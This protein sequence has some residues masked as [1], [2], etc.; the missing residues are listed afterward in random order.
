MPFVNKKSMK[1]AIFPLFVLILISVQVFSQESYPYRKFFNQAYDQYPQVPRGILEAVAWT[2][3]HIRHI[4]PADEAPSCTGM[5]SFY[6]VMGLVY[7]GKGFFRENLKKVSLLSGFPV[8]DIMDKPDINILAYASAWNSIKTTIREWHS[9]EKETGTIL[10]ALSEL[11][12]EVHPGAGDYTMNLFIYGVFCFLND[13]MNQIKYG[14]PRYHLDPGLLFGETNL[15]I[16]RSK[17]IKISAEGIENDLGESYQT[18]LLSG[19][20]PDYNQPNCTWI[21]S[22]NHY[23]GWNGHTISAIAIHTVQGSYTS[24]INWF[25]NP[26]A[27]AS[28]HYV[29]ASNSAY[30]GQVTQMV[31][32]QNA[33]W[34]VTSENWYAIGYEHEGYVNDPSWY[35]PVM[36]QTSADL[37]RDVCTSQNINPLR[38]FYRETLDD[39]TV[40]D[41]GLHSLGAEGSCVKIKGHQHFPGQ[42]H[43]DP[44]PNWDWDYYFKLVNSSTPV[45][46]YTA[47]NGNF[48]DSGGSAGFY[49][50]DERKFWLI[51]PPNA[52]NITLTFTRFSLED[53]YDFL[54][55]YDGSNEFA[56]LLGRFNTQSPATVTSSG[57][58]MFIEFRSDCATTDSGWIAAWTT[59]AADITDPSCQVSLPSAWANNDFQ[60][61]F[62]D[63][64]NVGGTGVDKRFYQVLEYCGGEWRANAQNGFFNDNFAMAMHSDWTVNAGGGSWQTASGSLYQSDSTSGNTNIYTP[65]SQNNSSEYLYQWSALM[66]GNTSNRRCGL[67]FFVT[68]P[69]L[70]NRGTSYLVWFRADDDKVQIYRISGDTLYMKVDQPLSISTGVWY[71]FKTAFNPVSG[72]IK[73]YMN[74]APVASWTDPSPISY[75]GYISLRSGNCKVRYDDLKV[76]RSR[77]ANVRVIAGINSNEDARC[78][79]PVPGQ[80]ACRIN[81]VVTDAAQNWSTPATGNIRLDFTRPTTTIVTPGFWKSAD[82]AATFTDSDLLSG[83]EKSFYQVLDFDGTKWGANTSRGFFGDNFDAPDT[84]CWKTPP[85]QG[86]WNWTGGTVTQTDEGVNNSNL[87]SFLNQNY[88]GSVLYHFTAM[89]DGSGTNRR[90]GFHYMCDSAS[91]SNRGNSYFVWFRLEGQTLEF[92]K[93]VNNN[94]GVAQKVCNN[95]VT[96][97]GQWYDFKVLFNKLNGTTAVF[98]NDTL[99]GTWTDPVPLTGGKYI[100]FRSG[101]SRLSV[102][103]LK[104]YR[105]RLG[106]EIVSTGPSADIRYCNPSPSV[107]GAKI[108][109]I[110]CDSAG[111]LSTVAYHDLSVDFTEP[112]AVLVSDGLYTDQDTT[113]SSSSLSANWTSSADPNSGI[114]RYLYS[115]GTVP[116][117]TDIA[118]W[119]D[120]GTSLQVTRNGLSL[121]PGQVYYFNVKSE[122][123]AGL[124]S[125]PAS[126]DGQ[127]YLPAT[128]TEELSGNKIFVM[129]NPVYDKARIGILLSIPGELR[130]EIYD[131][132]GQ[133]AAVLFE[134]RADAGFHHLEFDNNYLRLGSGVYYLRIM[135]ESLQGVHKIII[136]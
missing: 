71:D 36:Y 120:A 58:S 67:H 68:N 17:R 34:H 129:P 123:G 57:G 49:T 81:T 44:G 84:L 3:T 127:I 91:M 93:V 31:N 108:K 35:T 136:L 22:P 94:F 8:Q 47:S 62:S 72:M 125:L 59:T 66:D 117:N 41:N 90:F 28:T 76:W 64:D 29:V 4:V 100:S 75:G 52:Q 15:R 99:M 63:S 53:N 12:P 105:S 106:S 134:G 2:Q 132:N 39:G 24:C 40:L 38:M 54:Y 87:Y 14:F 88:P 20:C 79:S 37:T 1:R 98:R 32:E 5:P 48:Y 121:L 10:T 83:I 124:Q 7:D 25:Q 128:G 82:F 85:A 30:A 23:T 110:V 101:N 13:E 65:L 126:S 42:T 45:T 50:N 131:C 133:R 56:P 113:V 33:A 86:T 104:C 119:T 130:V 109:S 19:P 122:N 70:P 60:V 80:E 21:S 11:N 9:P 112:L 114:S 18:S 27:D 43:T 61:V 95:I 51:Q 118:G 89:A 46:T 115:I 103:E 107:S 6:G 55:I 135:N 96:V 26:S 74:D 102:S 69:V 73:V 97:P 78:E 16:F 116:G 92:Y 111:N 77:T